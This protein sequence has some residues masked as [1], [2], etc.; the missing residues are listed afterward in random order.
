VTKDF[1]RFVPKPSS[2]ARA[3]RGIFIGGVVATTGLPANAATTTTTS[4]TDALSIVDR[5]RKAA[6]LI[7]RLPGSALHLSGQHRS[8]RSHSSHSSHYSGSSGGSAPRVSP[9]PIRSP[10]PASPPTTSLPL[11]GTV[12]SPTAGVG[13]ITST[14]PVAG[15]VMSVNRVN[16]TFVF[17]ITGSVTRT[18]AFRDDT[19]FETDK[20]ASIRFDDFA[21]AASGQVP[22]SQGDK[23]ELIWEVSLASTTPTA[24]TI[25]KRKRQ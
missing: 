4:N 18:I 9:P 14:K 17:K 25:T 6:K 24:V 1:M 8:H 22:I 13:S 16:K 23:V 10:T 20:G 21:A 19:K 3:L 5:S 2:L 15:E 7:L 12:P 11:A